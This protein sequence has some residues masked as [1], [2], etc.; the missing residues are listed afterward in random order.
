[1]KADNVLDRGLIGLSESDYVDARQAVEGIF[2]SGAPGAGKSA[3][4][5]KQLAFAFLRIPNSGALILTAKSEET[6]AWIEYAEKCGRSKD[7]IV[8][9]ESSGLVFD[10]L[11]YEWNRPGRGA[12]DVENIVDFFS[13]LVALGKKDSVGHGHDP[14]WERGN[15][16][17]MRNVI[18]LLDLA[19]EQISIVTIDRCIKSLPTE[20]DQHED[21]AWREASF[22]AQLMD[23]VRQRKETLTDAQWSD[24]D[25]VAQ[26]LFHKWPAFDERPR[27][28]LEMTWSGMAD[29]FLFNPFNR[30]FCGGECTITPEMTTHEGKIV[31]V[32]FPLL[33]YGF[34]TA[35]LIQVIIKLTF[36]KAWLRRKIEESPNLVFLWQDEFQYFVTRRDNFFQQT[37][38]GSRVAVVC[39]TQNILNLAEEL[40][41][42]EPGAKTKSFLGNLATKIFLQQNEISTAQFAADQIGKEYRYI[43]SFNAG[44][45]G[46]EHIHTG[47]SGAKQLVHIVEPLEFTRLAKPNSSNPYAEAIVYCG[48]NTFNASRTRECPDG[49]NYLRVL[50]SREL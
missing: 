44:S 4:V 13:T 11:A 49:R 47:I 9:N 19:G 7:L 6:R 45:S 41:E 18:K 25:F 24:L 30:I 37:C 10:P 15:E 36:Q 17:L 46:N 34:E 26:F 23:R 38:R 14:F 28:S 21:E 5:G 40:G 31:L 22:C 29:K 3:N 12:G 50:F 39:L 20:P 2:I 48:G 1:M 33:E 43:D 35:R 42:Q 27:S 16:Q 32:D 8:F